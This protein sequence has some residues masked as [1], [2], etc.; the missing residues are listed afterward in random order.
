M[1]TKLVE[2]ESLFLSESSFLAF[3][4]STSFS[5]L[6]TW[7][8]EKPWEW[9][10]PE[11]RTVG[12]YVHTVHWLFDC[13]RHNRKWNVISIQ[14]VCYFER[15]DCVVQKARGWVE[16]VLSSLYWRGGVI[17]FGGQET[18]CLCVFDKYS[19]SLF[20]SMH[21]QGNLEIVGKEKDL[22]KVTL[23]QTVIFSLFCVLVTL[24]W[25]WGNGR[26]DEILLKRNYIGTM[27]KYKKYTNMRTKRIFQPHESFE[28]FQWKSVILKTLKILSNSLVGLLKS[29]LN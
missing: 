14:W 18:D 16:R 25:A 23:T 7:R 26:G 20:I 1:R 9:C 10:W 8:W 29:Q 2:P 12:N 6:F 15:S 4:N 28:N 24:R 21:T 11:F 27:R 13:S 22:T 3:I 17:V 19:T 5:G